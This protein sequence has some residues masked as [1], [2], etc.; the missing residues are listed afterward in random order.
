MPISALLDLRRNNFVSP[1]Y[2]HKWQQMHFH[3]RL[4]ADTDSFHIDK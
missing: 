4:Q 3:E 2:V 1:N